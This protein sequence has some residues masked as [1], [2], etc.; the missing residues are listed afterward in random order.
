MQ[1]WPKPKLTPITDTEKVAS[2]VQ[3]WC[4]Q[5]W[6]FKQQLFS[7]WYWNKF[8]IVR[9][10]LSPNRNR[11]ISIAW[12]N[13]F[14][15]I[16]NIYY[17]GLSMDDPLM[18][19]RLS[20]WSGICVVFS[21]RLL[22]ADWGSRHCPHT[23]TQRSFIN[24]LRTSLENVFEDFV[25]KNMKETLCNSK[26]YPHVLELVDHELMLWGGLSSGKKSSTLWKYDHC[27]K[28]WLSCRNSSC[29]KR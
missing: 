21:L 2:L 7:T 15:S 25:N 14:D 13:H 18:R 20:Y 12:C 22:P 1:N 6:R 11:T 27:T 17:P 29:V 19:S 4:I 8:T 9:S 26:F 10:C 3:N 24:A 23:R 28:M 16:Q 5:R